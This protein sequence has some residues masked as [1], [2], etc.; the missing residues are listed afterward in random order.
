MVARHPARAKR[1][2]V[3]IAGAMIAI[4]G[5]LL[6]VAPGYTGGDPEPAAVVPVLLLGLV[7]MIGSAGSAVA[8]MWTHDPDWGEAPGDE[9]TALV[10]PR[11]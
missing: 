10:A 2:T 1:V 9:T 3:A 5:V 11:H 8:S 6:G 7:M 4:T